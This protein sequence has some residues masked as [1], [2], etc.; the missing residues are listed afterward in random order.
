MAPSNGEFTLNDIEDRIREVVLARKATLQQAFTE[1]DYAKILVVSKDDFREILNQNVMRL[2]DEQVGPFF[3]S[4]FSF[5]SVLLFFFCLLYLSNSF[6]IAYS[7]FGF[8]IHLLLFAFSLFLF[9]T[10]SIIIH[11]NRNFILN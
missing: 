8:L 9:L 1:I 2:N 7:G 10:F 5:Y 11:I 4:F 6:I 3:V